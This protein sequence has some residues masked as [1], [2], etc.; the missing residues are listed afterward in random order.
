MFSHGYIGK[1]ILDV[2]VDF[3]VLSHAESESTFNFFQ[4]FYLPPT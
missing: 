2:I 1:I 3:Y 4:N